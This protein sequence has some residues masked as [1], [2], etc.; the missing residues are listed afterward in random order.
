M[1]L[2]FTPNEIIRNRQE[3]LFSFSFKSEITFVLIT[4]LGLTPLEQFFVVCKNRWLAGRFNRVSVIL[5][6]TF[7][8][9]VTR[10]TDGTNLT[11]TAILIYSLRR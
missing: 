8:L 5:V 11:L 3:L 6:R 2:T 4:R 1:S 10:A 9:P 7:E